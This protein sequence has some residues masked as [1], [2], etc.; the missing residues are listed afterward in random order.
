M[1]IGGLQ[2]LTLIDYPGKLAAIVFTQGCNLRCGYCH[3][4]ELV[5]SSRFES[6]VQEDEVLSF[7]D[8]RRLFL[9]GVV[10]SGGEPTLQKDLMDFMKKVKHMGF[11]IKL[12]T[13][14]TLPEVLG[15]IIQSRLIDYIAMDIKTSLE[16]YDQ[17][18]GVS[19][20]LEKI[21][22]SIRLIR[23]SGIEFEFRTTAVKPFCS[24][25]DLGR[26]QHLMGAFDRYQIQIFQ[27]G[28]KILDKGLLTE[29]HYSEEEV[30]ALRN[31]FSHSETSLEGR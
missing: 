31:E 10:I 24:R 17:I 29:N 2:K 5:L 26:I 25:E 6:R 13:N 3:N 14:G 19:C 20:L 27:P 9:N 18:T 23:N 15:E 16:R 30:V 4:P 21:K 1:R 11:S 7:L 12:D 28:E 8:R 22:E